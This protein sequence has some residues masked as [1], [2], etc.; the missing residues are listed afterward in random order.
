MDLLLMPE[1]G[2]DSIDTGKPDR[3]NF[4]KAR[5]DRLCIEGGI[6]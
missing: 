5:L 2:F 1:S 4:L 3:D 6:G